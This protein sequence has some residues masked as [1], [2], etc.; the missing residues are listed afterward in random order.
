MQLHKERT[1]SKCKLV[2]FK[3]LTP[4]IEYEISRSLYLVTTI[5]EPGSEGLQEL[6]PSYILIPEPDA[7]PPLNHR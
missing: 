7:P 4:I 5:W 2:C 3:N 6:I 1:Y